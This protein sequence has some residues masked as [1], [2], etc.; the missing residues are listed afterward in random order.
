MIYEVESMIA[1]VCR[2][3]DNNA[4]PEAVAKARADRDALLVQIRARRDGRNYD[5]GYT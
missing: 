5:R 3:L 2:L 4:S 1:H